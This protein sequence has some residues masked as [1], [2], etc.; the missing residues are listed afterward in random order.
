ME[1]IME[2]INKVWAEFK[3]DGTRVQLHFAKK[4]FYQKKHIICYLPISLNVINTTG[5]FFPLEAEYQ[6]KTYIF[7]F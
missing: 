2:R 1:E 3:F 4:G 7:R 5:N 6:V